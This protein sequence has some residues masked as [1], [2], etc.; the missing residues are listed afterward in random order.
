MRLTIL[1]GGGFRVPLVY[2]ALL[3]GVFAA[4]ASGSH[5]ASAGVEVTLYD[6]DRLRLNVVA[7]I[8][9]RLAEGRSAPP[10]VRVAADLDDALRGADFVF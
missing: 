4:G 7:S 10:P 3:D 5:A 8:L 2:R 6:T 9:E 1:G